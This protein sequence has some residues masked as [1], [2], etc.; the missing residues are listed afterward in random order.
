MKQTYNI[1]QQI[2]NIVLVHIYFN[3]KFRNVLIKINNHAL[4]H[5]K[6]YFLDSF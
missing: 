3:L 2:T 5:R 6:H 1:Q 4:V